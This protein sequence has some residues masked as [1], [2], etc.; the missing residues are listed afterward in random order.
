[1]ADLG[2]FFLLTGRGQVGAEPLTGG[3][4]PPHVPLIPTA[5]QAHI[6]IPCQCENPPPRS[7]A[8]ILLHRGCLL[9][10]ITLENIAN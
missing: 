7:C 4:L 9:L 5:R 3:N 8:L 1:M 6:R 2:Q 10:V